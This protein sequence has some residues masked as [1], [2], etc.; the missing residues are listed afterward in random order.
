MIDGDSRLT[1]EGLSP[2]DRALM[3]QETKEVELDEV[4]VGATTSG[5]FEI[6]QGY[7]AELERE[8]GIIVPP[9]LV[10]RQE[11]LEQYA[12]EH[13]RDAR[14][15]YEAFFQL[16]HLRRKFG[17]KVD[18]PDL[19]QEDLGVGLAAALL[20][21]IGKS[22]SPEATPARRKLI[23]RLYNLV[24]PDINRETP[25]NDAVNILCNE[26]TAR[27]KKGDLLSKLN[28][29]LLELSKIGINPNDLMK[30]LY[31]RHAEW[32]EQL[33]K[34]YLDQSNPV[35]QRITRVASAH[36]YFEGYKKEEVDLSLPPTSEE[37]AHDRFLIKMLIVLDKYQA[38]R[39]RRGWPAAESLA[40]VREVIR[41]N[42][43]ARDPIFE[44]LVGHICDT[45]EE[46]LEWLR[47]DLG[48][49]VIAQLEKT[50]PVFELGRTVPAEVKK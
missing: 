5:D 18:T 29:Y 21:D 33:L 50:T 24:R 39:V 6:L 49:S 28:S 31:S 44:A 38:S 43:M 2:H 32:G 15:I 11:E 3:R 22:G 9:E 7:D 36:H 46:D 34:K 1:D 16:F 12:R 37:E 10:Q 25:I 47:K 13:N 45:K 35:N 4:G 26:A 27:G 8:Y 41:N 19:D 40:Y 48:L 30:S 42:G 17:H 20:H 14:V 23:S